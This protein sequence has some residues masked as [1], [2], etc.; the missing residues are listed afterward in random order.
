MPTHQQRIATRG[1]ED[2]LRAFALPEQLRAW[3]AGT[4][5]EEDVLDIARR[6]AFVTFSDFPRYVR[7]ERWDV[8]HGATCAADAT[9]TFADDE[10]WSRARYRDELRKMDRA[11]ER[12]VASWGELSSYF[13]IPQI[14][15]RCHRAT[16]S[17]CGA[18]T[19]R[20][21]VLVTVHWAGRPLSR[22][23]ALGAS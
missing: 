4:L 21:S 15:A 9:V 14:T 19:H 23:Y 11:S 22:E 6:V 13:T 7:L 20:N 8:R 3:Y 12:S 1:V 18:T 5:P 10:S 16:C 2:L 17:G